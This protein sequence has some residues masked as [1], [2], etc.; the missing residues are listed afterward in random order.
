M[1]TPDLETFTAYWADSNAD[2]ILQADTNDCVHV[3][4]VGAEC[5]YVATASL[6]GT[7][8]LRTAELVANLLAYPADAVYVAAVLPVKSVHPEGR[9]LETAVAASM[10]V[11][12]DDPSTFD[13]FVCWVYEM[14]T[15]DSRLTVGEVHFE[16]EGRRIDLI[17]FADGDD[18]M[19]SDL[20]GS[21]REQSLL[22]DG[23]DDGRQVAQAAVEARSG[24][25]F[26]A[27]QL[28][29][30]ALMNTARNQQAAE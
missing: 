24:G 23:P 18:M 29:A 21:L 1:T 25:P 9:D 20:A 22:R 4:V 2:Y 5:D 11:D 27:T 14:P 26:E 12:G 10:D 30:W 8:Q 3:A 16:P 17:S 19:F 28:D 15:G 6:L 7:P 13:G